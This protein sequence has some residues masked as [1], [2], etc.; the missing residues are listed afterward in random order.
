MY[1]DLKTVTEDS[2]QIMHGRSH[3]KTEIRRCSE[4]KSWGRHV[5]WETLKDGV[6]TRRITAIVANACMQEQGSE[7]AI[8]VSTRDIT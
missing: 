7:H 1:S 2:V 6:A 3:P 8:A 4:Q 5:T